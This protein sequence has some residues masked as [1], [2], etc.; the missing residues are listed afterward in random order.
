MERVDFQ[1][2]APDYCQAVLKGIGGQLIKV[3]FK[4]CLY[5]DFAHFQPCTR[6]E[7][8]NIDGT[9][10]VKLATLN[11]TINLETFLPRLKI[12]VDSSSSC[13]GQWSR[14]FET[15]RPSLI[16]LRTHC[17]HFDISGVSAFQWSDLPTLLPNLETFDIKSA[18][19][20]TLDTICY[21]ILP[22][23]KKLTTLRLPV[24][25]TTL[26]P[27]QEEKES[28]KMFQD[29]WRRYSPLLNL[30]FYQS[31]PFGTCCFK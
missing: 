17:A 29:Q 15:K 31:V 16:D 19:C 23:M 22:W 18:K 10:S 30:V 14:I 20:L 2:I 24:P 1:S 4:S 21:Q 9:S 25:G 13:L 5:I 28:A 11:P 6:L 27:S 3:N 7:E 26:L 8:M 12:L